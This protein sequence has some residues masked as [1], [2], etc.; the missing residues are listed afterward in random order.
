MKDPRQR[1]ICKKERETKR[2]KVQ[3]ENVASGVGQLEF[4]RDL[5]ENATKLEKY[6]DDYYNVN[7]HHC[8]NETHRSP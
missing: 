5:P 2:Q 8:S 7:G 6:R 4:N 3:D 1:E